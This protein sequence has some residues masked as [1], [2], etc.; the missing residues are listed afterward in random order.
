VLTD[1]TPDGRFLVF[2]ENT[3]T[4]SDLSYVPVSGDRKPVSYLKTKFNEQNPHV[5]PDGRWLAYQSDESGRYEVY[6]RPFPDGER[7]KVQVSAEGGIDPRWSRDGTEIFHFSGDE[8][9][10]VST[11]RHV[12]SHFTVVTSEPLFHV[13]KT[14]NRTSYT[15]TPD[16]QR[17]LIN[18][19]SETTEAPITVLLDWTAAVQR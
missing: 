6:V 19:V 2:D 15:V 10:M 5:S 13:R 12:S 7:D 9:L 4:G 14:T 1:W 3:E 18:T 11:V 8:R 17:F 16:G